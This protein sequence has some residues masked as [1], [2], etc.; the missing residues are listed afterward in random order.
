MLQ[1]GKDK[2]AETIGQME[3]TTISK[4]IHILKYL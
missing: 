4:N 2:E 1:D 3:N